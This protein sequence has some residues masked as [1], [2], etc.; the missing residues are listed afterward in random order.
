[1]TP[2]WT[3]TLRQIESTNLWRFLET[4]NARCGTR[5]TCYDE[6]YDWSIHNIP[7]FWRTFWDFA[8]VISSKQGERVLSDTPFMEG[9][10]F[11]PD[12][13]LNYAEN[14][15]K[16]RRS[17]AARSQDISQRTSHESESRSRKAPVMN[18]GEGENHESQSSDFLKSKG[19]EYEYAQAIVFWGEDQVKRHLDFNELTSQVAAVQSALKE[20]GVRKGDCVAGFMPNMPETIVAML[21][22]VS[23]GAIW[24][25]CSPDFGLPGILDRFGQTMPK[26]LFTADGYY[27]AGRWYSSLEKS[28]EAKKH[29]PSVLK[30]IVVPYKG[31]DDSQQ[32]LEPGEISY[33]DMIRQKDF[34][35]PEFVQVPFNHPL[36]IMYSSGTTGVPKCIVHGHGGTLLQHLKEHQLHCDIHP[37]DRVF[38]FTTCGWMM[39]NW[40]A[41]ALASQ[42]TVMLFDGSPFHPRPD[43]LFE[44][45]QTERFTLFGTSAR[46]IESL[47]KQEIEPKKVYDLTSLRLITSTGSPLSPEG[48][49]Y[50][51]RSVASHVCLSSISGGTDI[52]SCF[53]LGNPIGSVWRGELQA[54]GLGLK[55]EVFNEEGRSIKG[56]KGELVCTAPFPSMPIGFWNDPK[57]EKYHDAY[58]S[59][60]PDV[61]CHG[62]YVELT[63]HNGLVIY[64]RSDSTLNPNG[65]RIGTAEIYRQVEHVEEVLECIAIGQ[66]FQ[67]DSRIILFVH[68]K[69]GIELE[70]W[71]I[72]KIKHQ[73]RENTT[74]RHVPA[75]ILQV[76]DIPRTLN[77]KLVERA[78]TE[79]VHGRPVKN[80]EAIANPEALEFYRDLKELRY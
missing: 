53:A 23:L 64:G 80:K 30:L 1:M 68:L 63:E 54:R 67:G 21:A 10:H 59:R 20:W 35:R 5:F 25:S 71:L 3:P 4:V 15:L 11:F 40:L 24:T 14:L 7:D 42:A 22:A 50:I 52:I 77:G 46:F 31:K 58:F 28:R 78:V 72:E 45:A 73:I 8:G 57:G 79:V 26:V 19:E 39:W 55:V 9:K 49:D 60:F 17:I 44:Y 48:F 32:D 75:L 70:P 62:D 37:G 2:L 33:M 69:E 66:E 43:F 16:N 51:Y 34:G 41:S 76:R 29:L 56:Q 38:Y 13:T 65:V 61:W 36:F 18:R 6:L 12:A 27:Y 47:R 74:P